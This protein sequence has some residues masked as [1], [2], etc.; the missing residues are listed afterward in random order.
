MKEKLLM[1][2]ILILLSHRLYA[3]AYHV[4]GKLKDVESK[5]PIEFATIA[6]KHIDSDTIVTSM[7]TDFNGEFSFEIEPDKYRLDIRCMGYTPMVKVIQVP[8]NDLYL[9]AIEMSVENNKLG[10]I[11][12]IG[13]DYHEEHDR[14]IQNITK[15]F[16]EGTNNVKDLLSKI[17]GINVDPLDKSITVDN[18]KNVLILVDGIKKEQEYVKNLSPDRVSRIEI[19]RNPT[20]RYISEGYTSVINVIL[21]KNYTGYDL[22]LDEQGVYSLDKSNGDDF[23]FKNDATANLTYTLK[24]I[25]LYG[26]YSNV[27]TN[28]NILVDSWKTLG[29]K[30]L[31]QKIPSRDP[32]VEKNGFSHSYLLGLDVF[33]D[34]N[35]TVSLQTNVVRSPLNRNNSC[36]TYY[37]IFESNDENE[38]FLSELNRKQSDKEQYSLLSYRNKISE[39]NRL[40]LDYGYNNIKSKITNVYR[41]DDQELNNQE[42]KSKRNTLILDLNFKHLFNDTYTVELGYRNTYRTY[43]YSYLLPNSE[44][45]KNK[46]VRNLIYSYLSINPKSKVK[47]KIGLAAEQNTLTIG[48]QS[49]KYNSLQPFL[50]I[51]Y[52]HSKN[53]NVTLKLNSESNYPYAEQVSPFETTTDRLTGKIG[54]PDLGFS[55]KYIWSLDF[56][57]FNNKLDIEP[58]Y[59]IT[60]NYISQAGMVVD[61][62]FQYTFSNLDRYE[63]SGVKMSTR[64]TLIPRKMYLNFAGT[65]Y[66]DKTEFNDYS[67][68]INDFNINSNLI[69]L[70][71]K[72]KTLYA[73]ILK[74]MN[75]KQIQTYGYF[76]D[77]NDYLGCFIKQ[78]F[79]RKK[80]VVSILYLLPVY[81]GLDY[82][83]ETRFNYGDFHEENKTNVEVLTNFFMLN[84]SFN[85]SRGNE[86]KSVEKNN[87]KDKKGSKGFF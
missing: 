36:H 18:E 4:F 54:N 56:K 6:V 81:T 68:K 60:R 66:F 85:L 87:Y 41:E 62:R 80:L 27:K 75:T 67:N 49:K 58:Y 26:S 37:N 35:Q 78:P 22:L 74:K 61:E 79:L 76:S 33:V 53:L 12:V 34:A 21:K 30:S 52:K 46:D 10:E 32:N 5:Q 29:N 71:S 28:T 24:R 20:G 42:L 65:L 57:L 9:K 16:K 69:Y 82:S 11:K 72:Y 63:S 84:L 59:S 73:L 64:L 31:V 83:M 43:H 23:L 45:E 48:N 19:T 2:V 55:T 25:N 86:I 39:K 15:Q 70:S 1:F 13:S 17:R 38:V 7:I 50:N 40:E 8:D 51:Y 14:S 3:T 47:W 44:D 77:N